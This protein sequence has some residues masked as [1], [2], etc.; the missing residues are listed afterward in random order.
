MYMKIRIQQTILAFASVS[1][2][3]FAAHSAANSGTTSG[4]LPSL[5]KSTRSELRPHVGIQIGHA[6]SGSTYGGATS[7]GLEVGYQ[8]YIPLAAALEL[9]NFSN[10]GTGNKLDR[11]SLM[12]KGTYNFGGTIPIIRNSFVGAALGP[13][14]DTAG[15]DST[16]VGAKVLAGLDFPLTASGLTQEKSFSLG[17]TAQYLAVLRADD[18]FIVNAQLKYWF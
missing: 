9:Q 18:S 8:P 16:N 2:L 6:D 4:T 10:D 15:T 12:A 3:S 17:A 11:T 5:Q 1:F 13:V 14:F 7:Y